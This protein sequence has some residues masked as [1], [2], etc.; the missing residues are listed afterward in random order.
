M[1]GGKRIATYVSRVV[2]KEPAQRELGR[3]TLASTP[4]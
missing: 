3:R 2:T 1:I 4:Q